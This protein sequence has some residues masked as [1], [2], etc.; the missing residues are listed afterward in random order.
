[1]SGTGAKD[2]G[3]EKR[4]TFRIDPELDQAISEASERESE[5]RSV[6]IRR[7]LRRGLRADRTGAAA[8]IGILLVVALAAGGAYMAYRVLLAPS[9]GPCAISGV[10]TLYD[11]TP[12]TPTEVVAPA[13]PVDVTLRN[14]DL[15]VAWASTA[16][17]PQGQRDGAITDTEGRYSITIPAQ[18][19]ASSLSGTVDAPASPGIAK[20]HAATEAFTPPAP[21]GSVTVNLQMIAPPVGP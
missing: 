11:M 12:E 9:G 14:A 18:F 20:F 1:M 15:T 21:G 8:V 7:A 19:C 4:L 13:Q 6:I 16:I 2:G 3:K 5:V 17:G 10:V